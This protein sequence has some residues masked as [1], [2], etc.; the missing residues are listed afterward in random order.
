MKKILRALGRRLPAHAKVRLR[1][2]WRS[3]QDHRTGIARQF[4]TRNAPQQP[5][6]PQ[7]QLTQPILPSPQ[8]EAKRHNLR[9]AAAAI[10][11]RI[12]QPGQILSFAQLVGAPIAERGFQQGRMLL[13]GQISSV[14][15]G[16]LCQLSG[17]LY[18]AALQAG[19]SILERHPHSTDIYTDTTRFAPLG[20]DATVVYGYKDL[21]ILNNGPAPLCFAIDIDQ[22]SLIVK[23]CSQHPW[24][25]QPIHYQASRLHNNWIEI[26]GTRSGTIISIDR[27]H[28]LGH[29]H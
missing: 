12:I 26:T 9:L 3:Y 29:Q 18:L 8:V 27:Y 28:R 10:H 22:N 20:S 4:I 16:G 23:L 11:Q 24:P 25:R 21:R 6:H 5:L 14:E 19:L 17:I 2:L 7:W 15:G 1:L 13:N